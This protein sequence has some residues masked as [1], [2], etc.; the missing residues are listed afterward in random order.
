MRTC[1]CSR[2]HR[3]SAGKLIPLDAA[4]M[5]HSCVA[6]AGA[7][8]IVRAPAPVAHPDLSAGLVLMER[9]TLFT[10]IEAA[11]FALVT[12]GNTVAMTDPALARE[13]LAFA[14]PSYAVQHAISRRD[15]STYGFDSIAE[16]LME[17]IAFGLARACDHALLTAIVAATPASFSI[18]SAAA[19]GFDWSELRSFVGTDGNGAA[20]AADGVLRAAGIPATLTPTIAPTVAGS[21]SRAAVGVLDDLRVSVE[22]RG[23][24]GGLVVTAWADVQ[25]LLPN[26]AAF[27]SIA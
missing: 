17:S 20:L 16:Q 12:D 5:K 27:W 22:R 2:T 19:A 26:A 8:I 1:T 6:A 25:A 11:P 3:H 7:T 21:F 24:N 14:G 13:T 10:L 15:I 23:F 18:G 9:P 4:L